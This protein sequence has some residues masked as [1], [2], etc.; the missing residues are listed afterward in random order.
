MC[1]LFFITLCYQFKAN[2]NTRVVSRDSSILTQQNVI[3]KHNV[4]NSPVAQWL[5]QK[6]YKFEIIG[7]IPIWTTH[8]VLLA[9]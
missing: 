5:E 3:L 8:N 2:E 7:S 9:K 4:F 6:P 1:F